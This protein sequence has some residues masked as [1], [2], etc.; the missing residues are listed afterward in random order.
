MK[1]REYTFDDAEAHAEVHRKSIRGL[2]S[3]D[4]SNEVIKAWS[5]KE[6]EDSPLEEQKARFVAEEDG[7]IVGFSDYNMETNELSGLYMK[8]DYTNRG[9]G[10]K[11]LEIIEEDAREE[12]LNKLWC[13]STITAKEFYR[14]HGYEIIEETTHEVEGLDM[15]VYRM[16]KEL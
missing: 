9:I 11:L 8:P 1:I 15:K 13:K 3:E 5:T 16:E 6:P 14:K 7:K 10:E 2:A 12:G 4:Y